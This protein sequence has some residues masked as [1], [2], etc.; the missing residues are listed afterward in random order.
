MSW[1]CPTDRA[2]LATAERSLDCSRCGSSYPLID[3]VPLFVHDKRERERSEQAS[4]V[5]DELWQSMRDKPVDE[6]TAGFC[7]SRGC[8]RSP[9]AGDL[10]F[11]VPLPSRSTTLELGAGFGDESLALAG[12]TG[13]TISIVPSLTNAR[14]VRRHLHERAGREWTV[15]VSTTVSRLPL[16]HGSVDAVV[17]EDAAAAGF[18]LSN[19]RLLEAAAEWKRVLSPGGFVFLELAN[20]L[21]RL[22]GLDYAR[23]TLRAGPQQDTL[24][25]LIKRCAT[26]DS[27]RKLSPGRTIRTMTRLGFHKPIVYAPLPDANDPAIVLPVDDP[28]FPRYFLERLVRKNSS[29]VRVALGAANL[30]VT[31]GLFR[32]AV[33][34]Y[35]L[36]FRRDES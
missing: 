6:A 8:T 18:R 36:I 33:P 11:V 1:V 23:E 10:K 3:G 16:A 27:R 9:H 7:R 13:A 30:L 29:L 32:R 24:N 5:L 2:P 4:P 35:Y 17:M 14:I 22:P 25:R 15:G 19:R 26:P 21:Y 20:D 31:L 12:E 34:A 28:Q